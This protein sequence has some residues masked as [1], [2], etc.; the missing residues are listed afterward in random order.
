M[1]KYVYLIA[2]LFQSFIEHQNTTTEHQIR[3]DLALLYV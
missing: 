1:S 2:D 3:R